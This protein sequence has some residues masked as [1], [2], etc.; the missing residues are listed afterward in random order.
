VE[1]RGRR[2]AG[3]GCGIE[4]VGHGFYIFGLK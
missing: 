2:D 4:E 1:E 3:F